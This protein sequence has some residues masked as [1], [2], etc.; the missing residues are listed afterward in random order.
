LEQNVEPINNSTVNRLQKI[1]ENPNI[2][3]KSA[4]V[5]KFDYTMLMKDANIE[6]DE[7][8]VEEYKRLSKEKHTIIGKNSEEVCLT[9]YEMF[10]QKILNINPDIYYVTDVLVKYLYDHK[11]I[12][13]KT[14]L[15]NCFGDIIVENLKQNKLTK[16]I[17]CESCGKIIVK[18]GRRHKYCQKC[19]TENEKLRQ[20]EKWHKYKHK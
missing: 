2:H 19:W 7:A 10:R 12:K 15:W 4:G 5:D 20:R 17:Y 9:M 14:T 13:I 8:I 11:N 3:F 6:I 1:I 18:E 16:N